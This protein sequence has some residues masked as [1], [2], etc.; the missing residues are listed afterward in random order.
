M[1]VSGNTYLGNNFIGGVSQIGG[2]ADV[3]NNAEA[4]FLPAGVGGAVTINVKA[5]TIAADGVPGNADATDQDFALVAYNFTSVVSA[6]VITLDAS[7]YGCSDVVGITVVDTDLTGTGSVVISLNTTGADTQ[8]RTLTETPANSGVF[9][10]SIATNTGTVVPGN[11]SLQVANGQVILA[12]YNDANDGT[13]HPAVAT[14]SAA[15][16]YVAPTISGVMTSGITN[17]MATVTFNTSEAATG[18][19]RYGT[20]CSSLSQTQTSTFVTSG[21]TIPLSGLVG[22]TQY[23]FAVD[24][25]DTQGNTGTNNNGGSCFTFTTLSVPDY[26]TELFDTSPND[27]DFRTVTFLIDPASPSYYRACTNPA[28]GFPTD[29]TG[30]TALTLSDDSFATVTPAGA[31]SLYG[32]PYS[33]LQVG[34]NGYITLGATGDSGYTESLANH[35]TLPR[36]SALFDDLNPGA[37]GR[38]RTKGSA[39]GS[40]S[41]GRTCPSSAPP[42][43]TAS[44]SSSSSSPARSASPT[45]TSPPP[46]GWPAC[47]RALGCRRPSSKAI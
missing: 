32:T 2:S 33:T 45:S 5:M 47:R 37:G 28:A 17:S 11:G 12:T 42:T 44:R 9:V 25:T 15:V 36:I 21:H 4:V 16:D 19:V 27:L 40:R 41:P 29:P 3:R 6:G 18:Q 26:F 34:S 22:A 7:A 10:G 8:N 38:C 31:V 24:A 20:S 13:G 30:G 39:I 43:P 46:T 23:F 1:S 14:D 35:F